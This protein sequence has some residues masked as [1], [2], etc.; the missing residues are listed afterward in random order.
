MGEIR[1]VHRCLWGSLRERVH[2]GDQ[3]VDGRIILRSIFSKLEGVVG[4]GWSWLRIGTGVGPL[5][6][7]EGL[8]SSINAGNF[9]TSCKVY[10]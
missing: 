9:L 8:S 1:G 4:T 3:D 10:C 5:W 6:V 7:R 2:W